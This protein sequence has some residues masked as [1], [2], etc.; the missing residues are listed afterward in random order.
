M[1]NLKIIRAWK[2]PRFRSQLSKAEIELLPAHPAGSINLLA[3]EASDG[4]GIPTAECSCLCMTFEPCADS[5][6]TPVIN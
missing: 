5:T 1:N 3:E 6:I 4:I 2:N